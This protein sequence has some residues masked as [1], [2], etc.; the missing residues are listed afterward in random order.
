MTK[1]SWSALR[2]LSPINKQAS[3]GLKTSPFRIDS[4]WRTRD[5]YWDKFS[6]NLC[7]L[8]QS[9]ATK[10]RSDR[11]AESSKEVNIDEMLLAEFLSKIFMELRLIKIARSSYFLRA[12]DVTLSNIKF[13]VKLGIVFSKDSFSINNFGNSLSQLCASAEEAEVSRRIKAAFHLPPTRFIYAGRLNSKA[14]QV[15]GNSGP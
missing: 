7:H 9:L 1:S 11:N 14:R 6:D 8:F 4:E 2:G 15:E 10:A 3:F 13:A 5:H 12:L